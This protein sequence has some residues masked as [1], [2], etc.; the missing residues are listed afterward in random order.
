MGLGV[1]VK[2]APIVALFAT[3]CPLSGGKTYSQTN[4]A[5]C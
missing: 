2:G 1:C 5:P 3:A 4:E